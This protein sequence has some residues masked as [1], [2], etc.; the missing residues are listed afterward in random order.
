MNVFLKFIFI[1]IISF[2]MAFASVIQDNRKYN[3]RKPS[4]RN[5]IIH[6]NSVIDN[7]FVK[8]WGE[9]TEKCEDEQSD[10][11]RALGGDKKNSS[12]FEPGELDKYISQI[13]KNPLTGDL[14]FPIAKK[15]EICEEKRSFGIINRL[16]ESNSTTDFD[17]YTFRLYKKILPV[18]KEIEK[19]IDDSEGI[20]NKDELL[21]ILSKYISKVVISFYDFKS[22]RASLSNDES[23]D[24]VKLLMP[25]LPSDIKN[26]RDYLIKILTGENEFGA[27]Q[28]SID[29]D[30][31]LE[32]NNNV[33][34]NRNIVTL[35]RFPNLKRYKIAI[36]KQAT[37][38]LLGQLTTLGEALNKNKIKLPNSCK[39][40]KNGEL[41]DIFL[42]KKMSTDKYFYN[43]L[44]KNNFIQKLFT[45]SDE[46][47]QNAITNY[48]DSF[49]KILSKT[50]P[51]VQG[52]NSIS[53]LEYYNYSIEAISNPLGVDVDNFLLFD[54]VINY[55]MAAL[56]KKFSRA[57]VKYIPFLRDAIYVK[58]KSFDYFQELLF[59]PKGN[60][61]MNVT[62]KSG[63]SKRVRGFNKFLIKKMQKLKTLNVLKTIPSEI[64]KKLEEN[65][66]RID[67]PKQFG[68]IQMR[69]WALVQ[70]RDIVLNNKDNKKIRKLIRL[71][72]YKRGVNEICTDKGINFK[73]I[74]SIFSEFEQSDFF[75]IHFYNREVVKRHWPFLTR[76]WINLR[77]RTSL[78]KNSVVSEYQLLI[79]QIG[80]KDPWAM[81]RLSYL[82]ALNDLEAEHYDGVD[83]LGSRGTFKAKI[84]SIISQIKSAGS[85]LALDKTFKPSFANYL[86]DKDEKREVWKSNLNKINEKYMNVINQ[87][88]NGNNIGQMMNVLG[89]INTSS[90]NQ[91]DELTE[92]YG[93]NINPKDRTILEDYQQSDEGQKLNLVN[94]LYS[95]RDNL[96]GMKSTFSE[97][98]NG[99][100]ISKTLPNDFRNILAKGN[101]KFSFAYYK[102]ILIRAFIKKYHSTLDTLSDLC[103]TNQDEFEE[104]KQ[105]Y[106]STMTAQNDLNQF[107]GLSSIPNKQISTIKEKFKDEMTSMSPSEMR[108]LAIVGVMMVAM[109][110]SFGGAAVVAAATG[111]GAVTAAGAGMGITGAATI[112][113]QG[114][115]FVNEFFGR[116]L[117]SL[118]QVRNS[119]KYVD[120]GLSDDSEVENLSRGIGWSIFE[121]VSLIPFIGLAAKSITSSARIV[122]RSSSLIMRGKSSRVGIESRLILKQ[123]DVIQARHAGGDLSL[124]NDSKHRLANASNKLKLYFKKLKLQFRKGMISSDEFLKQSKRIGRQI[125]RE[126][127]SQRL[128]GLHVIKSDLKEIDRNVVKSIVE[129][130]NNDYSDFSILINSYSSKLPHIVKVMEAMESKSS[131]T[132]FIPF[133]NWFRKMRY[134][135]LFKMK[136]EIYKLSDDIVKAQKNGEDMTKFISDRIDVITTLFRDIPM[137]KRES[138]YM[139]LFSGGPFMKGLFGGRGIPLIQDLSSGLVMKKIVTARTRLRYEIL[140]MP[141]R[142]LLGFSPDLV[143][144]SA[145]DSIREFQNSINHSLLKMNKVE[146]KNVLAKYSSW[147]DEVVKSVKEQASEV[148]NKKSKWNTFKSFFSTTKYDSYKAI[149]LD[150]PNDIKRILFSPKSEQENILYDYLWTKIDKK[151]VFKIDGLGEVAAEVIEK[152]NKTSSVDEFDRLLNALKILNITENPGVVEIM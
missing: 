79:N 102:A 49:T 108:D 151:T 10:N 15:K 152:I 56:E 149:D 106:F 72:C 21:D 135:H 53:P 46:V 25:Q 122:K 96:D 31:N 22:L 125:V 138:A 148:I 145:G 28:L 13:H 121:G 19:L 80:L 111:A 82:I 12:E 78:I 75:P 27:Y 134:E 127:R 34:N 59:P 81:S 23:R 140:S 64:K 85:I 144:I 20:N 18:K 99:Y 143:S 52:I 60:E 62:L 124:W 66:V 2:E 3:S 84:K 74:K 147:Q 36:K 8:I 61:I 128:N 11:R 1:N 63:R 70:L 77:N 94:R 6:L 55:K 69:N 129:K 42:D 95:Q 37:S 38:L 4:S 14:Y 100:G 7:Y 118:E 32:I 136:D 141:S 142:N 91:I 150:N 45:S 58:S 47:E 137:R 39:K 130:F 24:Y 109:I 57:E 41:Q 17:F 65:I 98:L 103:N 107:L 139:L 97:L 126:S 50:S 119:K 16:K 76:L 114:A 105:F 30:Y 67:F 115:I 133:A 40:I 117:H 83:Y 44:S 35:L 93:I 113:A 48:N 51:I 5:D 123:E 43:I 54:E 68:S 73:L 71:S 92:K 29:K 87:D 131:L 9:V 33:M 89:S 26:N 110:G 116:Y 120:A 86:L 112:G 104:T 90:L 146:Q 132:R 88:W 101:S